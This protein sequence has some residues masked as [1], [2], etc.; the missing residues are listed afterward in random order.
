MFFSD[1]FVLGFEEGREVF[2]RNKERRVW[3]EVQKY[4]GVGCVQE[5]VKFI[6]LG[7]RCGERKERVGELGDEVVEEYVWIILVMGF[8]CQAWVWFCG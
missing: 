2:Q 7:Y 5:V 3:V 1:L 4:E 8:V 6:F